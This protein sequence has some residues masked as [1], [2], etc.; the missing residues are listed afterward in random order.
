MEMEWGVF[1]RL[2]L[3]RKSI[4]S[5]IGDSQLNWN[6]ASCDWNLDNNNLIAMHRHR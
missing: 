3:N 2:D 4:V 1:L 5:Q 6:G